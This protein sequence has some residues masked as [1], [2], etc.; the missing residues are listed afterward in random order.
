MGKLKVAI[1]GVGSIG[2]YHAREFDRLGTNVVAIL[3]RTKKSAE[4][5]TR[6]LKQL[7]GITANAYSDLNELL[8]NERLDIV[9]VCTSPKVHSKQVSQCLE[10]NTHVLCEKPMSLDSRQAEEVVSAAAESG[11]KFMV[12]FNHR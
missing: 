10:N 1:L 11:S 12:G 8:D 2:Q 3:A 5:K 6:T 7:Y 4:E 9:S